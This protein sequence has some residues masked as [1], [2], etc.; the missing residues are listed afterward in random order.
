MRSSVLNSVGVFNQSKLTRLVVDHE[1]NR[2]VWEESWELRNRQDLIK[3]S[4]G[5]ESLNSIEGALS[6]KQ[7]QKRQREAEAQ[8]VKSKKRKLDGGEEEGSCWGEE[9]VTREVA[10]EEFLYT[11]ERRNMEAGK[12]IQKKLFPLTGMT[13]I[14]TIIVQELVREAVLMSIQSAEKEEYEAWSQ[15]VLEDGEWEEEEEVI[16]NIIQINFRSKIL[17]EVDI[18]SKRQEEKAEKKQEA[19]DRKKKRQSKLQTIAASLPKIT[20]FF[21]KK[22]ITRPEETTSPMPMDCAEEEDLM[23]WEDIP[24]ISWSM[25]HQMEKSRDR[26]RRVR[27]AARQKRELLSELEGKR[28][29]R[30]A[31]ESYLTALLLERGWSRWSRKETLTTPARPGGQPNSHPRLI[32]RRE[33][34]RRSV[35]SERTD[36]LMVS[37]SQSQAGSCG[38]LISNT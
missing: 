32:A 19:L 30:E 27:R 10:R 5:E 3:K 34:G 1:W 8:A 15:G 11:S 36:H 26:A 21:A 23:E 16:D 37:H 4:L 38:M 14:S 24:S 2:K 31:V 6:P 7:R 33:K 29:E 22:T 17:K 12:L 13:L 25:A 28:Q 35:K 9:L 18:S 20:S